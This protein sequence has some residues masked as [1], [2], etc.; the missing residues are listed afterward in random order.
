MNIRFVSIYTNL[1][2]Y[3]IALFEQDRSDRENK[4]CKL[5]DIKVGDRPSNKSIQDVLVKYL[6]DGAEGVTSTPQP[7]VIYRSRKFSPRT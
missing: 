4:T 7:L 5:I 1:K 2:G 3:A 6:A